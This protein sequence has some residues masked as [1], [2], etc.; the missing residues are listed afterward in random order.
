MNKF[1]PEIK[2]NFG[3][4]FMR[5]PTVKGKVD[6]EETSKMVDCFLEQ[7][8]NYFDTAHGYHSGESEKAIK[9]CLTSRHGREE[10]ILANKLSHGLFQP[11][12][13]GIRKYFQMQ[14]EACGVD[15]FDFY[16]MHA[17][18]V[19]YYAD[20]KKCKAYETALELKE[21]GKIRHFGISFHDRPELLEQILAEYPQIEMVQI[22]FNYLDYDDPGIQA[23]ECYK[24]CERRGVPVAVMEPVRGGN[25]AHLPEDAARFLED[26]GSGASQ[27]SYAVRYAASFP[28]IAVVLSGMSNLAQ[29]R[30]NLSYMKDFQPVTEV[31]MAALEKV[32]E[33]FRAKRMIA[34]TACRY[35]TDGCPMNIPIPDLISDLNAKKQ[36][37]SWNA[38]W[39]YSIHI[40]NHGRA[41]DCIECGQCEDV[42]P[43]RLPIIDT[44]KVVAENFDKH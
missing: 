26:L 43:Q 29:L 41:S 19:D 21:E 31:E 39:Y 32:K 4:G 35:C 17:Q 40:Q 12:P 9:E 7:G 14:L 3:F 23:G 16:L 20:F 2:K 13:E 6:F 11:S 27:A 18:T 30:D 8:F 34:C 28:G 37:L 44:M 15:Y 36:H 1:Y 38:D 5:L 10:Y 42:C 25:L 24:V 33:A 22:Q